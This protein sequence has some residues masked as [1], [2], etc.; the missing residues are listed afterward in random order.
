MQFSQLERRKLLL[1]MGKW[2]D[3]D[4]GKPEIYRGASQWADWWWCHIEKRKF[5]IDEIVWAILVRRKN[6]KYS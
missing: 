6:T 2:K 4:C 1:A 5:D 3:R